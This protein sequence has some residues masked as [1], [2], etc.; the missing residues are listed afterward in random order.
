MSNQLIYENPK[1]LN[2]Q[3]INELIESNNVPDVCKMLAGISL[4]SEDIKLIE[5]TIFK[6]IHLKNIEI[7]SMCITALNHFARRYI[8][9]FN[10]EKWF[11]I[12]N[13][14]DCK[15]DL[16]NQSKELISDID[17]YSRI[18]ISTDL[19]NMEIKEKNINIK[20]VECYEENKQN[21][22]SF[23]L[24][25]IDNQSGKENFN[26]EYQELNELVNNIKDELGIVINL[27]NKS[28]SII[29]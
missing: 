21:E 2:Q 15:N 24:Y 1:L 26:G 6:C 17:F 12:I 13:K 4:Y 20:I 9:E 28:Y 23:I 7:V 19:L 14:L 16:I 22:K 29:K 18:I 11:N 5:N 8:N 10:K 3:E 25:Y 27:S